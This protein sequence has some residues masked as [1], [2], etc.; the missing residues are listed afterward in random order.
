VPKK[1]YQVT[2]ER[3]AALVQD[4]V[5]STDRPTTARIDMRIL[6]GDSARFARGQRVIDLSDWLGRGIDAWVWAAIDV[7]KVVLL[8]GTRQTST[9][10]GY[11]SFMRYF[12]RYLTEGHGVPLVR[13]PAEL[14][15][16]HVQA[17]SDWLRKQ[18]QLGGW[19]A[20]SPR[21]AFGTVK[22]VLVVMF[23]QGLIPGDPKRYF[24]R[25]A[26]PWDF[27]SQQTALSD[28]E[29]ESLAQAIK[30]ELVDVHHGRLQ[31]SARDVQAIRLLL[32][33]IRQGCNPTPLLEIRRDAV[34]PGL[35]PGTLRIRILKYRNRKERSGIG[36]AASNATE[37][38][39]A[40][41]LSEGAVLNR[42][43]DDSRE[44]VSKAP[45]QYK[46]RIWL[47]RSQTKRYGDIVT[48]L[49]RDTLYLAISSLIKRRDLRGD[50]GQ[51]LKLNLSRLRKSYFE[52]SF[53][54]ADGDLVITA[55]LMGNTPRVAGSNYAVMNA[56]RQAEAAEFMNSDFTS[57]MRSHDVSNGDGLTTDSFSLIPILP[58]ERDKGIQPTQTPI[59]SCRD[60]KMGENAPRDGYNHCDKYVMCLFCPSFAV[61][62]EVDEIW[63]LFSFQAF[64]REEL[65]H[66][67]SA[68]GPQRTDNIFMEELR[69]RYRLAIPY[70]DDIT[71]RQFVAS[72]VRAARSKTVSGLHP[73]W[74][75]HVKM[76][77]RKR[78]ID[79][80][81]QPL[82]TGE[83]PTSIAELSH[84]TE[85]NKRDAT[86][87]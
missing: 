38:D 55:N 86:D 81:N 13:Y 9:V 5:V 40:F 70:I 14:S 67:D 33:A 8:S 84:S 53:R 18:A 76:S 75:H 54:H 42:A 31:L 2:P 28:T 50:D 41:A 27:S 32:V 11:M 48:C 19:S 23:D 45:A 69:D 44:L 64:A 71:N 25:G 60:T 34:E 82:L 21:K 83:S 1:S 15:P 43:I 85:S 62:G 35:L 10:T 59:A 66:L 29:Q 37:E 65:D 3:I 73:F 6:L 24:L 51:P 30:R 12:F 52:R 87:Q 22:A 7:F 26:L 68:L 74:A 80:A 61:V 79:L 77:R 39:M 20:D 57:F 4:E 56:H 16:L 78:G 49:T 46:D 47:Y 72:R 58:V 63:R 36:R 17:F